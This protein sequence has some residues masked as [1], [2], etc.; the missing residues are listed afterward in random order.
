MKKEHIMKDDE[1]S[2]CKEIGDCSSRERC[3][4]VTPIGSE[5]D[6]I[7]RHIDGVIKAAIKPVFRSGWISGNRCTYDER[8]RDN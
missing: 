4:V 7:R 3:F 5:G 2:P 6:P 1:K 8:I